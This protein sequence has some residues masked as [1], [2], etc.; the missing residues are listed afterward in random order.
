MTDEWDEDHDGSNDEEERPPE[1]H[2]C[3]RCESEN[4]H[5]R[6]K[7]LIFLVIAAIAFASGLAFDQEE[8]AFYFI[9]AAAIF[10]I[11]SDRWVCGECGETWK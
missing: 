10:T 4:I 2:T 7:A 8:A 1:P 11:I 3:P 5:R 9:L 6:R